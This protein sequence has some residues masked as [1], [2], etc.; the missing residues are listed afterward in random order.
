M[1]SGRPGGEA[2]KAD[3]EIRDD[4]IRELR[5]GP[6]LARPEAVGVA[7]QDGAVVL[8]GHAS[9]DAEKLAAGRAA[10]RVNGVR[11]VANELEVRL[12]RAPR[13]DAEIAQAV[14]HILESNVQIPP[15]R[16]QASVEGG[17]VTLE[18]HVD[19]ALQRQG[20]ERMV[21]N[22]R[23]VIGVTNAITVLPPVTPRQLRAQIGE[24]F[25]R[26]A[27]VDARNIR[28][29]VV[30]HTVELYGKVRSIREAAVAVETAAAAPG[31][32]RVEDHLVVSP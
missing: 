14:A 28:V 23:G 21:R 20:V 11:A 19:Q 22:V 13:D 26:A 32:S 30:D 9:S 16:V 7:V 15:G 25:Q 29:E 4:V 1:T 3:H 24:A 27:G 8:T 5:G 17:R 10:R 12:P 6:Q 18:G 2:M 31:V